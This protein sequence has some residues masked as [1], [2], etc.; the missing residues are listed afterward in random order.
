MEKVDP[1]C[2]SNHNLD[3][4]TCSCVKIKS[5]RKTIKR[6]LR[7]VENKKASTEKKKRCPKGF[8]RNKKTGNC[9]PKDAKK[10]V[11]KTQRKSSPKKPAKKEPKKQTRKVADKKASPNRTKRL[12][13]RGL[14]F[15][16]PEKSKCPKGSVRDRVQPKQCVP[17]NYVNELRWQRA[18]KRTKIA[19]T[20]KSVPKK[21]D[22]KI[23]IKDVTP[24][25]DRALSKAVKALVEDKQI[26]TKGKKDLV[27]KSIPKIRAELGR[28]KSF[29]PSINKKLVDMRQSAR[30]YNI[31]GCGLK[32][33]IQR[34]T[35]TRRRRG[36]GMLK[37][38]IGTKRNGE[39][40]CATRKN[41]QAVQMLLVCKLATACLI[42]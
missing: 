35:A 6:K 23:V 39:P 9:D 26:Q 25:D 3:K 29:S 16:W 14:P 32:D 41:K 19:R 1:T 31:F 11:R 33:A 17:K 4:T 37:V 8:K 7:I 36:G 34:K 27:E 13:D 42:R 38:R 20:K 21:N 15:A 24:P 22:K 5:T 18:I 2:P 30:A 12:V 10:S 40:D 28:Q